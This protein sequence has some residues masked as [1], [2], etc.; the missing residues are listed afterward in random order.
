MALYI[1]APAPVVDH[2][3]ASTSSGAVLVGDT[4]VHKGKL[5]LDKS[6]I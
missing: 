6:G 5:V 1:F 4:S 3:I 2:V